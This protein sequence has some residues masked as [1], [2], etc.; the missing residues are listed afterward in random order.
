MDHMDVNQLKATG[1]HLHT[2]C[3]R[4][5]WTR[6]TWEMTSVEKIRLIVPQFEWNGSGFVRIRVY[7]MRIGR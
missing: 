6:S 2:D 3:R 1:M 4:E 5:E 7:S